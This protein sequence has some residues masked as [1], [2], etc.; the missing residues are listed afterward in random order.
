VVRGGSTKTVPF[1]DLVVGDI[2]TIETGKT[3]PADCVLISSA[4]LVTNESTLT[5]ETEPN[6]KLHVTAQNYKSNPNAFLLKSTLVES[7]TGKAIVCAV[8]ENTQAGKAERALDIEDE[9]TP[10]QRKLDTIANQIGMVGFYVAIFTFSAL[11][12]KLLIT[13]MMAGSTSFLTWANLSVVLNAFIIA[14]TII[15]V[16][17]PE[18]LPLAVTISLAFSVQKM[19]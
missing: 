1:D 6:H 14:V 9:L 18:G 10:L 2:I 5:G 16:A 15:V 13:T 17:V 19:F 11:V 3:V 4:D 12:I 7:G 8:G